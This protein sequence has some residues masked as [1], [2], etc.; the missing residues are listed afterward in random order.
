VKGAD[1]KTRFA[2]DQIG[3][4]PGGALQAGQDDLVSWN[5][6]TGQTHQPWPTDD[7]FNPLPAKKVPR[8]G[9]LYLSDP[10]PPG[11]SSRPSYGVAQPPAPPSKTPPTGK[12]PP[13]KPAPPTQWTVF[14]YCKNHPNAQSEQGTINAQVVPAINIPD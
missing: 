14:Y 4:E 13:T 1:G 7:K 8:G 6:T 2:P 12:T 9:P 10:I 5:N 11:E 3:V